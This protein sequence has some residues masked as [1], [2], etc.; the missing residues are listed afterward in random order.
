MEPDR[1]DQEEVEMARARMRAR[2]V[3]HGLQGSGG[4]THQ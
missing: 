4:A 2:A 3:L 1:Q